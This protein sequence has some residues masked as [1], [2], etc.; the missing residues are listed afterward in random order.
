M[1]LGLEK[2]M[3][4]FWE[5][6]TER[7]LGFGAVGAGFVPAA[8]RQQPPGRDRQRGDGEHR[9]QPAALIIAGRARRRG[10]GSYLEGVLGGIGRD[11]ARTRRVR[12]RFPA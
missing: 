10:H 1:P 11:S 8:R 4:W 2:F 5:L 7:Q 12:D 3:A 9:Q 6:S